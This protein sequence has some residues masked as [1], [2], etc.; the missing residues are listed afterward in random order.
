MRT[1][2]KKNTGLSISENVYYTLRQNIVNLNFKP[3]QILNIHEITEKLEVSRT[4]VREALIRL[5]REG[6]VDVIPQVG[7]SVSKIDLDRIEEEQFIRSS[8]E[9]KA[10]ELCL[11][12]DIKLLL[13]ELEKTLLHQEIGLKDS[14]AII[15]LDWDDEFHHSVFHFAEKELSWNLIQKNSSHYRRIRIMT[16]WNKELR[17][18]V[19]EQHKEIYS[20][21]K[22][23]DLKTVSSLI[24]DHFSRIHSQEKELLLVYPD[25]FR[26]AIQTV[27]PLIINYIQSR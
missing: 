14:D 23:K 26:S 18:S 1:F 16:L 19:F 15:F 11:Q 27:D 22:R 17:N 3:G 13:I 12:K 10:L 24:L 6:L 9:E 2:A 20:F 25:Y 7:T 5:E 8:L 4:P 21:I